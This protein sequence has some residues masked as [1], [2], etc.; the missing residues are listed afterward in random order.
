MSRR[1]Q[2]G[3]T[4]LE[5][6]LALALFALLALASWRLFDLL[7]RAQAASSAHAGQLRSVQ[8]AVALIERDVRH[9]LF[10][11]GSSGALFTHDGARLQWLRAAERNLADAPRSALRQVEYWL[12]DGTLWR[13]SR[14]LERHEG[15]PQAVL[16]N[17]RQLRWRFHLGAQGWQARQPKAPGE[18]AQALELLLS[19][20]DFS[21][22]RRVIALVEAPE[23]A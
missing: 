14:V 15:R 13:Y 7:L 12:E 4:L 22:L 3:F 1:G 17:V 18:T 11:P 21:E 8:R 10:V 16:H 5:L 6:L 23:D 2:Q 9:G 20:G 19:V